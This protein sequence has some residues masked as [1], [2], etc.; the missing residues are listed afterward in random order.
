MNEQIEEA[1]VE[2]PARAKK[3]VKKAKRK[4]VAEAK[5]IVGGEFAGVS[6]HQ[7]CSGCTPARCVITTIALCGHPYKANLH[8]AGPKTKAKIAAVK[9]LLKHQM[10]DAEK[11]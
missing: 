11:L 9:K 1:A 6:A 8:N 7:C 3:P 10:I 4:S 2:A 5:P